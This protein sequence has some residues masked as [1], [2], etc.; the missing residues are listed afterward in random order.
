MLGSV[1]A[2]GPAIFAIALMVI[3]TFIE[4]LTL[5]REL[6]GYKEFTETTRARLIPF[7]W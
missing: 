4:D 2:F 7:V 5:Q 1:I 6:A 3:R